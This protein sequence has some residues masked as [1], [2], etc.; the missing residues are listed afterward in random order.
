MIA[1]TPAS[2]IV[3]IRTANHQIQ[4]YLL[5]RW[6]PR[7]MTGETLTNEELSSLFEAARWAPSSFNAQPWK[8]L[9]AR[10]DTPEW[11]LFYDLMVEFN[12]QW[13][14]NAAALLVITS[15]KTFEAGGKPNRTHSFDTGAAW[16]SLALEGSARG[17]VVHGMSGFDYEQARKTLEI[18][19][20]YQIEAM[21]AIGK[22]APKEQLPKE[23][24]VN[25]KPNSR[26]PISESIAE[27]KFTK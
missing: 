26:R 6:S 16:M 7:S 20:D 17:L 12:Q 21:V 9:Y 15:R 1:A 8:F 11:D 3:E 23:M 24:Q 13:T 2:E 5:S 4:P 18:P 25:E 14:K 22:R 19:E 27:G 10:R